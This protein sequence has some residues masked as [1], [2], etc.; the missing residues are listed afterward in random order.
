MTE[1]VVTRWYRAPEV[2]LSCQEYTKAIDMWSVGCIYAELLGTKPL[3]PGD[4][5]IHQLKLIV[6]FLGT[7][8]DED[9]AFVKSSRA[10]AFMAKQDGK[11]K[12]PWANLFP[13][14]NPIA[15]DLLD[16][17]LTF[18]PSKRISCEEALAHPYLASLHSPDDEPVCPEPFDFSFEDQQMD[19]RKLQELMLEQIRT[20]HP[21]I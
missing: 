9:I 16:K 13:K 2:M 6:D 1:Y 19:K 12:V 5:Y 14:A 15:L 8:T 7:P 21:Q 11:Q 17:L 20:F 4:D 10:R 3:F 18:N